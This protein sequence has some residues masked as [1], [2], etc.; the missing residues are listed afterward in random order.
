MKNKMNT[1]YIVTT[2]LFIAIALVIRNFAINITAGGVLTMRI[3]FSAVFYVLPGFLFGPLYG[4]IAGGLVDIL[5]YIMAPMGGYIP[6]LTLTNIIAGALPALIFRLMKNISV[7]KVKKWYGIFFVVMFL[8][9]VI[10]FISLKFMP[11]IGIGKLL[12]MAGKRADYLGVGLIIVSIIAMLLFVVNDVINR[13][14]GRAYEYINSRYFK[15]VIALGISG[16]LVS[17]LNT[18]ILL[19]FIPSLMDKGFMLLW[20]PRIFQCLFLNLINS[21]IVCLLIYY[22]AFVEKK[23][24]QSDS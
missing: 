5:G 7:Y 8:I 15:F 2:G 13:K 9:G 17:T 3:S 22:Y 10:N 6:L 4:G 14:K 16:I 24:L 11:T 18:C 23:I 12:S 1:K 20:I 21:Y 19:I